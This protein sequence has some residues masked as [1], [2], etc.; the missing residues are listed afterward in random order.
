MLSAA[1]C[2]LAMMPWGWATPIAQGAYLKRPVYQRHREATDVVNSGSAQ[3]TFTFEAW[4]GLTLRV[5][6]ST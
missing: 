6:R 2:L 4:S 5:T 1:V 3:Q